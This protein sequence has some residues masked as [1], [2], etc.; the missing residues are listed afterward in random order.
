MIIQKHKRNENDASVAERERERDEKEKNNNATLKDNPPPQA[1]TPVDRVSNTVQWSLNVISTSFFYWIALFSPYRAYRRRVWWIGTGPTAL[2]FEWHRF[3]PIPRFRRVDAKYKV[4]C[5]VGKDVLFFFIAIFRCLFG[6][7]S[8]DFVVPR[9]SSSH[10]P[11]NETKKKKNKS[12]GSSSEVRRPI[13][14]NREVIGS[15]ADS[16]LKSKK[17]KQTRYTGLGAIKEDC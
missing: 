1:L 10:P 7:R 3:D 6:N 13:E 4:G 5:N 14:K 2:D 11:S 8:R 9:I 17:N 15:A 12:D 16:S